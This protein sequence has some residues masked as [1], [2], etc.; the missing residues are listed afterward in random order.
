MKGFGELESISFRNGK[1]YFG[2]GKNGYNFYYIDYN[3]FIE[4]VGVLL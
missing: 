3:K 4:D 1:V 2:F